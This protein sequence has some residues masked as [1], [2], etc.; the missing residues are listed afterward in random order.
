[1]AQLRDTV[2]SGRLQAGARL[3]STR[4]LADDLGVSRGVVVRAYEQL[5][6][7]GYFVA[8]QGAGTEVA[9]LT[10]QSDRPPPI[11]TPFAPTNPGQI[12]TGLFPRDELAAAFAAALKELPATDLGYGDPRGLRQLRVVL[13][14]W[15]GRTR[16]VSAH[17]DQLL[18][19]TGFAQ[20]LRLYADH[21]A[22]DHGA[23][24]G[25]E[26]P[27]SIGLRRTLSAGGATPILTPVDDR[28][29]IVDRLAA[30]L[31]G[32]VVTPAHQ[33]PTGVVL[34]PQRRTQLVT[35]ASTTGALVLE[36]DYDREY[37]FDASPVGSVHGLAPDSVIHAGSLSK[38][39]S[40]A[41]RIGWLVVPAHLVTAMVD[42]KYWSDI[43]TSTVLQACVARLIQDG[44]LDRI[45]RRNRTILAQ[46]RH[47]LLE[48][49]R[50]ELPGC[51]IA[52]VEAGLH[53]TIRFPGPVAIPDEI[54]LS[55]APLYA[56]GGQLTDNTLVVGYG[57]VSVDRIVA[58]IRA[59]ARRSLG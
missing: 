35:W 21:L 54:E 18:I 44:T 38:L 46:R 30:D 4:R 59:L 56:F 26:D 6:A 24:V 48:T 19:T 28:G 15:L 29:I 11:P 23:M 33:F 20:G 8:T 51:V 32:V 42:N 47:A 58:D 16:G 36:D 10:R 50:A 37:R 57:H 14:D 9:L 45:A 12:D 27:G 39:L 3:P 22:A 5:T 53:A 41:L 31:A 2:R 49:V 43:A 25:V 55:V 7:E 13:A 52:G 17:P 1:M 34:A 40:P